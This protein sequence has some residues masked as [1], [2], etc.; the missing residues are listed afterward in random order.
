M[1]LIF[2]WWRRLCPHLPILTW[3]TVMMNVGSHHSCVKTSEFPS[4]C[5]VYCFPESEAKAAW[6]LTSLSAAVLLERTSSSSLGE[7]SRELLA[8]AHSLRLQWDKHNNGCDQCSQLQQRADKD[9]LKDQQACFTISITP[10]NQSLPLLFKPC[11]HKLMDL[12]IRSDQI[13]RL[14]L[15]VFASRSDWIVAPQPIRRSFEEV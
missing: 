4:G 10:R 8:S 5:A 12:E 14:N 6:R 15:L 7:R 3:P 13:R 1:C 11:L 9:F 2:Q